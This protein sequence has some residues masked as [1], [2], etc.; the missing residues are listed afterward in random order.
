MSPHHI[1]LQTDH[2]HTNATL[3]ASRIGRRKISRNQIHVRLA[4]LP[5]RNA[6][7]QLS[8]TARVLQTHLA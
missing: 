6:R 8:D 3:S 1:F 2:H 5:D 4:L 7:L